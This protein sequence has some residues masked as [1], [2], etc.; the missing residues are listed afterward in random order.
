MPPATCAARRRG[1]L[2]LRR[3]VGAAQALGRLEHAIA[4]FHRAYD[5][6]PSDWAIKT[7][8]AMLHHLIG[9][10]LFNGGDFA[11]AELEFSTAIKYNGKVA[12]FFA[13]YV[14]DS[15]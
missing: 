1:A 11:P 15:G 4:D 9:T 10:R 3:V 8:L 7:R 6:A 13:R 2:L 5:A 12:V 14:R